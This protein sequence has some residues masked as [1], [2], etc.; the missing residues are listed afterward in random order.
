M[1]VVSW[2]V[3]LTVMGLAPSASAMAALAVPLLTAA[4][5]CPCLP[6]STEAPKW[7]TVGVSFTWVMALA[8]L[9]V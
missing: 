7:L 8:T 3:T 9:A 5:V 4:R 6:T 2:A 1:V